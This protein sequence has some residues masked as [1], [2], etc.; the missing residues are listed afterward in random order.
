M[1]FGLKWFA[2]LYL[3]HLRWNDTEYFYHLCSLF[4]Y[5][6]SKQAK[7][8]LHRWDIKM[9][10]WAKYNDQKEAS[11]AAFQSRVKMQDGR[12]TRKQNKGVSNR[13]HLA[14]SEQRPANQ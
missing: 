14:S 12:K 8:R 10:E 6:I 4:W 7:G 1:A 2:H 13:V 3:S 5:N 11:K 9:E